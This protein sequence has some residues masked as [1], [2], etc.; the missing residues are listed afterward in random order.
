MGKRVISTIF[1]RTL[2][3][4]KLVLVDSMFVPISSFGVCVDILNI[5]TYFFIIIFF[6]VGGGW[7]GLFASRLDGGCALS[8]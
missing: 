2:G 6:G 3:F 4:R 1:L 7:G 5:L 8:R